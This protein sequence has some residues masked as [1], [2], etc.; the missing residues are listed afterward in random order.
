MSKNIDKLMISPVFEKIRVNRKGNPRIKD[1]YK[2]KRQV[3]R[4]LKI[5]RQERALNYGPTT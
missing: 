2:L 3:K 1:C 5:S 4:K